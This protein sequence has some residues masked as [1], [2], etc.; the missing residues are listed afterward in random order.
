M[1]KKTKVKKS[2]KTMTLLLLM[3]VCIFGNSYRCTKTE[4]VW[5]ETGT[6]KTCDDCGSIRRKLQKYAVKTYKCNN[7]SSHY[8]TS[9]KLSDTM[10]ACE[11]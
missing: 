5:K 11:C 1:N 8:T 6:T 3:L 4:Y 7:C 10:W 2:M 9:T